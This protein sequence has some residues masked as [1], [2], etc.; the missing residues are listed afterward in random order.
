MPLLPLYLGAFLRA[1]L[2]RTMR[3]E[4]RSSPPSAAALS[5]ATNLLIV[6]AT[7]NRPFADQAAFAVEGRMAAASAKGFALV[8]DRL[9]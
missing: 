6:A 3:A 2:H 8:A 4:A 5:F 9:R 1:T 7:V